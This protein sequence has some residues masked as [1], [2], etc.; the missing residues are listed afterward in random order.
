LLTNITIPQDLTQ[1]I[2][3][4]EMEYAMNLV[5]AIRCD[6][7][8]NETVFSVSIVAVLYA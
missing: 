3:K 7:I 4:E 8:N 6:F 1:S 5:L 2:H